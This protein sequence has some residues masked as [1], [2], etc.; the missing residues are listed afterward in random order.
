MSSKQSPSP[1]VE[2]SLGGAWLNWGHQNW[3]PRAWAE[4]QTA[5]LVG[6]PEL[7]TRGSEVGSE[8]IDPG[9][10]EATILLVRSIR[11]GQRAGPQEDTSSDP[12]A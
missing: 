10:A 9:A 4:L 5:V 12:D 11:P 8:E 3:E 1:D 7:V 2:P 6:R